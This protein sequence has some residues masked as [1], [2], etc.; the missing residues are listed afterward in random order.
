ML[1]IPAKKSLVLGEDLDKKAHER[2][3]QHAGQEEW[4]FLK[5]IKRIIEIT[6]KKK[7]VSAMKLLENVVGR[8]VLQ[9]F[10]LKS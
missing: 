3:T 5:K 10:E 7:N 8:S 9:A 4:D 1:V 2:W 6:F